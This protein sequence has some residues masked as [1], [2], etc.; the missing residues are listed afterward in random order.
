M[1]IGAGG[2]QI[3]TLD[4]FRLG[5]RKAAD[6]KEL[7]QHPERA[8]TKNDEGLN[9]TSPWDK[10][11]QTVHELNKFSALS[12][13]RLIFEVQGRIEDLRVKV[14]NEEGEIIREI[15]PEKAFEMLGEL[16]KS[17]GAIIDCYV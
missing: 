15:P 7:D 6:V 9:V 16:Q 2:P 8:E 17:L 1:K 14:I 11:V 10:V 5:N 3:Q 4:E 13:T 12:N